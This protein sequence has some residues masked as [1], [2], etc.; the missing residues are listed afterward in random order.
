[1]NAY[2]TQA[3]S[4]GSAA[5]LRHPATGKTAREIMEAKIE[6][7]RAS[8]TA[9]F[10]RVF[11]QVPTD[12]LARGHKIDFQVDTT[13]KPQLAMVLGG[14]S[15]ALTV[16]RHALGQI[17]ERANIPTRYLNDLTDSNEQWRVDLAAYTLNKF[18]QENTAAS[19]ARHLIRS[20]NG[21]ARAVLSDKY[22][23]LD[24]RP[25]LE[26]FG[27][28]CNAIGAVPVDGTCTD[29]RVALK[30]FLPMV[31]EPVLGEAMCLGLEW[32]N[33]DFGAGKHAIRAFLFRLWCLNGA[34]TEDVLAQVHLGG[35]INSDFEFSERTLRKDTNTQ[36]S[37][38]RDIVK[39]TLSP[40][41]VNE[42]L[43]TIA[44]ANAKEIN[45]RSSTSIVKKLLKEEA[46]IVREAFEGDDVVNL[47]PVKS[48]WR[49]SNAISWLA[50]KTED[51]DRKL[52][53]QRLAGAVA[54]GKL[55]QVVE[56][57]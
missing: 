2:R 42:L 21:E 13:T 46:K 36:I 6:S 14:G 57:A 24:S 35:V 12:A 23:R 33:S 31:F 50:G 19:K 27:E 20:V 48:V 18:F 47:P 55:E 49:M 15:E 38:L 4:G 17:A 9:L 41:K 43:A 25:L 3:V 56:A 7:G 28:E 37:A 34:T 29:T 53:L 1:M 32:A 8:G 45:W 54:V 52:E 51:A 16:H 40:G 5:D 44:Q 11:S 39:G 10:E 30:A 26:A 22:R